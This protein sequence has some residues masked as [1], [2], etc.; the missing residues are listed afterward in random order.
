[1]KEPRHD[2]E[3]LSELLDGRLEGPERDELLAYLAASGE[4]Y[5]V[6]TEAAA[7][8][9]EAEQESTRE[10][11][12]GTALDSP[13]RPEPGPPST[14]APSGWKRPGARRW[15]VT[16]VLAGLVVLVVSRSGAGPVGDPA[17][18]AAAVKGREA[19]Q[20][21]Y[22]RPLGV[23]DRGGPNDEW[24]PAQ[25]AK[26]GAYLM[27]LAVAIEEGDTSAT[28]TLANRIRRF[29]PL[30]GSA[31]QTIASR[32]GAPPSELNRLLGRA[33]NRLEER[34]EG[35]YLRVG[36]WTEAAQLAADVGDAEFFRSAE[37]RGMLRH[38]EKLADGDA[39]VRSA[40]AAIRASIPREGT[41]DRVG[42]S[43]A[44]ERL[45]L[46]IAS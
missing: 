29:D 34:G 33:T 10:A 21:W 11:G 31:L 44:V 2:D 28:R 6:F 36:T 20:G 14:K 38:A 19:P 8:L 42:L 46:A 27:R 16:A 23:P 35:D 43:R 41:P 15:I 45:F 5:E 24:T 18:M 1:M 22:D 39:E 7:I 3:R 9:L 17:H 30:G 4:D 32:A 12:A 13:Q 40:V 26:A 37:T 25:A